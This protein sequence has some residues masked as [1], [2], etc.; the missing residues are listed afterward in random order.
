MLALM[1]IPV[2]PGLG[3]GVQAA[4]IRGMGAGTHVYTLNIQ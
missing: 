2:D 4:A 3:R 1:M